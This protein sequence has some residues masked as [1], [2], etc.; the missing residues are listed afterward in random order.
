MAVSSADPVTL[1]PPDL[2]QVLALVTQA[3]MAQP[4]PVAPG[5]PVAI[6]PG[7]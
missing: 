4:S 2:A 5:L 1:Y 7:Q 3:P 6:Q